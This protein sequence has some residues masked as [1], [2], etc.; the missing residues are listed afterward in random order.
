MVI[1]DAEYPR[2]ELDL[3]TGIIKSECRVFGVPFRVSTSCHPAVDAIS[4]LITSPLCASGLSILL[5][6]PY[7]SPRIDA[8]D[9]QAD[10]R[11]QSDESEETGGCV[12]RR[13]LDGT[14]Y[15]C[16]L[17]LGEGMEFRRT[18]LHSFH[19]LPRRGADE[20]GCVFEFSPVPHSVARL[21]CAAVER[22]STRHWE[23][24]WSLGGCLELAESE[25]PRAFE[26]ERRIVL[27]Q[28]LTAIQ[29]AGSLPPQETGLSCNSWYGKFHLEMHYWHAGHFPL[30]QRAELLERSL[31]WYRTIQDAAAERARSQGYRG[32]RWPKMTAPDGADSPS[33]IGPLIIWE[34]PV[35]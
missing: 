21:S 4:I 17:H 28:Y 35:P 2:Q 3:W 9:W 33:P 18:G 7:G 29:C 27:S 30:W 16:V 6:F 15:W 12:I 8:S 13:T 10:D 23:Q 1:G 32:A 22:E 20:L 14:R 31:G 11:H 5:R 25:D 26:L 24:F 19:V 34:A